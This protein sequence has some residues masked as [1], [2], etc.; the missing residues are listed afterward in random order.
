MHGGPLWHIANRNMGA[1]GPNIS[2]DM[3]WG[4]QKGGSKFESSLSV[5]MP[6]LL[7]NDDGYLFSGYSFDTV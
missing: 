4:E 5:L 2:K 1:R 3:D 6:V 7:G